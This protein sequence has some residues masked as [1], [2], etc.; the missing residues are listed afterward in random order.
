YKAYLVGPG[1]RS[2]LGTLAPEGGRLALSRTLSVDAL[3]RQGLW[4]VRQVDEEMV[5]AFQD[6]PPDWQD[7]V[8]RQCARRLP[9]HTLLRQGEGFV[10]AFPFDPAR[11]FPIPALFCFAQMREGRLVFSFLSGG[12]PHIPRKTGHDMED[13][14]G[15]ETIP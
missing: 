9:R 5:Y 13:N 10:L 8:L 2:L 6:A 15:K 4:P 7:P 14:R 12:I 3:Q 11:P 1:R